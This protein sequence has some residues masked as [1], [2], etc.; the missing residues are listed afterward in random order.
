VSPIALYPQAELALAAYARE[1]LPTALDYSSSN[2]TKLVSAGMSESQVAPFLSRWTVVA[3]YSDATGASATVF[4]NGSQKC[5]AVRGTELV[6]SDLLTDLTLALGVPSKLNPQYVSLKAQ[7][8]KWMHDSQ[9]TLSGTFTVSGHSLGGYLAAALKNDSAFSGHISEAYLFNAPGIGGAFGNIADFFSPAF[10]Q[11]APADS[12]IWNVKGTMGPSVITGLGRQ[13]GTIV[14]VE[15]EMS[16]F[17]HGIGPLTDALALQATYSKVFPDVSTVELNRLVDA[18]SATSAGKLEAALDALQEIVCGPG[19]V[20]TPVG[21]PDAR[22]AFFTNLASVNAA[23]PQDLSLLS[24]CDWST[25]D[26]AEA[27]YSE[28]G[29]AFRHALM[30]L[31]PFVVY[32]KSYSES[33]PW[34][35]LPAEYWADR[36]TMLQRKIWFNSNEKAAYNPS[37]TYEAATHLFEQESTL[38]SDGVTGYQIRQG[39]LH[40]N[41]TRYLFGGDA[42]DSLTGA[43]MGDHLYG[44]RGSD[45]LTGGG[46]EDLL[47]G[48]ADSDALCGGA[49]GD[50]YWLARGFGA[51]TIS[52]GESNSL[53]NG[54]VDVVRFA[55]D[56]RPDDITV[57]RDGTDLILA[58]A[59]GTDKVT[60]IGWYSGTPGG[61]VNQ[62]ERA[63]FADGTVWTAEEMTAWGLAI[64]GTE[65][66]DTLTVASAGGWVTSAFGEGGD[67]TI[68]GS[69]GKDYLYGGGGHDVINGGGGT[70]MLYGGADNDRYEWSAGDG[71]D[72]VNTGGGS[73]TFVFQPGSNTYSI[74]ARRDGNDL[75]LATSDNGGAR[76]N[77]WFH[78]QNQTDVVLPDGTV[79]SA[80]QLAGQFHDPV[81]NYAYAQTYDIENFESVV[82]GIAPQFD[83]AATFWDVAGYGLPWVLDFGLTYGDST[84]RFHNGEP[85]FTS[86]WHAGYSGGEVH[87]TYD[88]WADSA[89][90]GTSDFAVVNAYI[91]QNWA[92]TQ[93]IDSPGI[94]NVLVPGK[95][96][97]LLFDGV[98]SMAA[99]RDES[100]SEI[101]APLQ[102][103]DVLVSD[104]ELWASQASSSPTSASDVHVLGALLFDAS[105]SDSE[106]LLR[107]QS[108]ATFG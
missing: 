32:G 66:A 90:P 62:I 94:P 52:E 44:G 92:Y 33:V 63:E 84:G 105:T 15:I 41:T 99:S 91:G 60:V 101:A 78:G 83:A 70:D 64:H 12:G 38:F 79:W 37:M 76:F 23:A 55:A 7:V 43:G 54:G 42:A 13:L 22:E 34:D 11:P 71:L 17:T 72:T 67:D 45:S 31:T 29:A 77:E 107:A 20:P 9:G 108:L 3:Q 26:V 8:D 59:N 87:L 2:K 95:D 96:S 65:N 74:E 46:G 21:G 48:G 85:I 69:G 27:A 106:T 24:L 19:Q 14:P 89:N 68:N 88:Y 57:T 1:L 58:H 61:T 82:R 49:A 81:V 93:L 97:F 80:E 75:V 104:S 10:S 28:Y 4:Q 25:K 53:L 40:A 36:A 16:S 100:S 73:D 102:M 35:S 51:D 18:M 103:A 98:S 47:C 50:V 30:T 6:P 86:G 39:G 5:L 56:V